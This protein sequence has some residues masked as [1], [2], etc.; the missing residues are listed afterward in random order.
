M[1]RPVM[2]I[3]MR[4]WR[5]MFLSPLA[6][7]LLAVLFAIVSYMFIGA[8]SRYHEQQFAY[9]SFGGGGASQ[10]PLT[11][12]VV[13]PMFGNIA[14]LLLLILPL[15]TMRLLA[16]EKRHG[17]WPAL[18]SSPI[19]PGQIVLGKYGG[20]LLFLLVAVTLLSLPAWLL[21]GF[22]HP[23]GGQILSGLI[24]LLLVSATFGAVGLAA[25]SATD[26]PM[27]AAITTFGILLLLWIAS[28]TGEAA[29]DRIEKILS[30]LSLINHYENFLKG[31]VSS[32]DL[33]YFLICSAAGL[34][35][36]RQRLVTD[37][38]SV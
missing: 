7:T 4:E 28:W 25:S 6:W 17:S 15:I 21:F 33:I 8:V 31:V 9:N 13:A 36:A 32:A 12:M 20:L 22:G 23:D 5:A 19:T 1:L 30:Y 34:L 38:I 27:V 2:A 16:D 10:L 26:N 14:V 11:D 37:R 24:G 29:G 3:A 18:A 35:Y